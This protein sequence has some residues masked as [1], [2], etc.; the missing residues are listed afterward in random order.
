MKPIKG[1]IAALIVA[2]F[3]CP[4][5]GAQDGSAALFWDINY[6]S[7]FNNGEYDIS[8]GRYISSGT[9]AAARLTPFIGL[10]TGSRET[11]RHRVV[12]GIDIIKDFGSYSTSESDNAD[13]WDLFKEITLYYRYDRARGKNTF[14]AA[15]GV[16]PRALCEGEYDTA[17]LSDANRIYDSNVEGILMQCHFGRG[18]LTEVILDWNGKFGT[19]RR[20]EFNVMTA[21]NIPLS[22]HISFCW[23]GMLHHYANSE[24]VVG[25]VDDNLVNPYFKLDLADKFHLDPPFSV[26]TLSLS[27]GAFLGYH[28][29]RRYE[30]CLTPV[31]LY[32]GAEAGI[33]NFGIKNMYHRGGN[34]V[35]YYDSM[36]ASGMQYADNLYMRSLMWRQLDEKD[37]SYDRLE[38]YWQPK[39]GKYT[40]L[41]I[42]TVAHFHH[43]FS[44]WQQIATLIFW[45]DKGRDL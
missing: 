35:P 1:I 40:S 41:K 3:V 11:G 24:T 32:V 33:G 38:L 2:L 13:N 37:K 20:E 36:D 14:T 29:D 4:P 8:D 10:Q 22:R 15:A 17:I 7:E 16:F 28:R 27:A 34:I 12:A 45:L 30:E 23:Q 39:L 44:G 19:V 6:L 25:V 31:G 26:R 42:S 43:S 9:I 21:G 5:C 18:G